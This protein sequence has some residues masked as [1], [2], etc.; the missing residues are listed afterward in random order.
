MVSVWDDRWI[1]KSLM[2]HRERVALDGRDT[3]LDMGIGSQ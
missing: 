3:E 1:G 2:A